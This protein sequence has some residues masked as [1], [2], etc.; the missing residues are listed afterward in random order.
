MVKRQRRRSTSAVGLKIDFVV[1]HMSGVTNRKQHRHQMFGHRE[2]FL[3]KKSVKLVNTLKHKKSHQ[4]KNVFY[5]TQY[6]TI[7]T[8]FLQYT[9]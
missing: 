6:F 5:F 7:V 2:L 8:F 1:M 3:N 9:Y 4:I